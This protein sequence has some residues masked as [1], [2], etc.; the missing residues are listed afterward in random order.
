[1]TS[2][3]QCAH[4]A[5]GIGAVG[6]QPLHGHDVTALRHQVQDAAA[7]DG[8]RLAAQDLRGH[9]VIVDRQR[10]EQVQVSGVPQHFLQSPIGI[11]VHRVAGRRKSGPIGREWIRAAAL[12]SSVIISGRFMC[13]A[14]C[15]GK[16]KFSNW[17]IGRSSAD[18]SLCHDAA[19]F[20]REVHRDRRKN[21]MP[22]AAFDQQWTIARCASVSVPSQHDAQPIAPSS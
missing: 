18:G 1:M 11:D 22:G 16:R 9:Q 20:V 7:R 21:V 19:H 4:I 12:I 8:V 10:G 17:L 14:K 5:F 2:A 3:S 6:D 15:S 13:T